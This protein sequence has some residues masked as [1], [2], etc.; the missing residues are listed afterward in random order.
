MARSREKYKNRKE[1]AVH[2]L[3]PV[4]H[5]PSGGGASGCHSEHTPRERGVGEIEE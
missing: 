4:S 3:P 2:S 1:H 5:G